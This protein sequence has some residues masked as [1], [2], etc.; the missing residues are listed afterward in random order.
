MHFLYF[1]S[2]FFFGLGKSLAKLFIETLVQFCLINLNPLFH[3]A[4]LE[5]LYSY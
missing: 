1:Q 3:Y 4:R 2:L 5:A